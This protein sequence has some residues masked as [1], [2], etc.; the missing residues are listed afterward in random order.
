M[1]SAW[2]VCGFWLFRFRVF[3][4][5]NWWKYHFRWQPDKLITDFN[6][7]NPWIV[8]QYA[9]WSCQTMLKQMNRLTG[10][11]LIFFSSTHFVG[12]L[13][14]VSIWMQLIEN[15]VFNWAE[16]RSEKNENG[17]RQCIHAQKQ[18]NESNEWQNTTICLLQNGLCR[19]FCH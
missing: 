6:V 15:R 16:N 2:L 9:L 10:C 5:A 4:T 12:F 17:R 1:E 18:K 3:H 14:V 13:F 19:W 8:T 7:I 11:V